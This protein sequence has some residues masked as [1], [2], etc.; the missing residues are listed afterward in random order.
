M[1]IKRIKSQHRRD[2]QAVYEC[3]H[4]GH[5][6]DGYGYDDA[7]FHQNVIPKMTCP[8]CGKGAADDYRPLGTKYPAGAVV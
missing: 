2:F 8:K 4:C 7:N 5:E 1:K 6:E 3:E